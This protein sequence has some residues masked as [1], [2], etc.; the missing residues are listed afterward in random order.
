MPTASELLSAISHDAKADYEIIRANAQ[1]ITGKIVSRNDHFIR[2]ER[3]G[4][5]PCTVAVAHIVSVSPTS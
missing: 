3:Q 5:Q 4:K 1:P 2:V